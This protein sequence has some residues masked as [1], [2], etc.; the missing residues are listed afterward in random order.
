MLLIKQNKIIYFV[1]GCIDKKTLFGFQKLFS[2]FVK[3]SIS[4]VSNSVSYTGH[5]LTDKE[6]AGRIKRKKC[7]R[8][9]QLEAKSALILQK[10]SFI[11]NLSSFN[12]AVGRTNTFGGSRVWDPCSL[13]TINCVL[14]LLFHWGFLKRVSNI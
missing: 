2:L 3:D 12:D 7:L 11:N 5:I 13:S 1:K 14:P 9:P 6:L 4:G 8:R 10:S